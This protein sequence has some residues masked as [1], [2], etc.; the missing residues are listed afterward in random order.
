MILRRVVPREKPGSQFAW[1]MG[2]AR[3]ASGYEQ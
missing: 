1:W 3:R 2:F